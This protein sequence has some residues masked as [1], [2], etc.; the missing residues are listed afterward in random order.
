MHRSRAP[1]ALLLTVALCV[2]LAVP[3][4]AVTSS[5]VSKHQDA[6]DR[7]RKLAAAAEANA[8][9]LAKEVEDLDK[10]IEKLQGE[11]NQLS[12]QISKAAERTQTLE[13]EVAGLKA[14]TIRMQARIKSTSESYARQRSLLAARVEADYKQGSWFYFDVLLGSQNFQDLISRTEL[15]SRVLESNNNI[16]ADLERTGEELEVSKAKLDRS[17]EQMNVKR[18][19]AS[20]VEQE[21]RQLR[22]SWQAKT[23]EQSAVQN[24]KQDLMVD[25]KANAKRLRALAEAEERES[26]RL[27]QLLAG[28]GSGYFAGTMAWPVPSST[29]VTSPFGWRICPFHGR[30]L[31]PGIDIGRP[32][33]GGDWPESNRSIIAAASGTVLAAGYRGGYGNTVILDHGNGVTTLYAHQAGGG[34]KVSVGESVK[35]GERIG[36][37][38]STGSSTGL[39]LHFEV[40]VNGTPKNPA[41]YR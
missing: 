29:R 6:A 9:K 17:L 23:N 18:R 7:A 26:E 34:I 4:A 12:P 27:S 33:A 40:R 20:A 30:E 5:D 13:R 25:N 1:I 41:T 22:S 15:V 16:A 32:S 14:E 31:H 39:H 21:L 3:A 38:G 24:Q 19:E 28:S 35:K 8:D 37:V 2:A 36:T 10:K 11:A